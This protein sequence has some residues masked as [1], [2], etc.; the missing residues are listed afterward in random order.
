LVLERPQV[1]S[2]TD[3]RRA[4]DVIE[5]WEEMAVRA[6]KILEDRLILIVAEE[7]AN[8]V[9]RQHLTVGEDRSR[10]A[11]T[12]PTPRQQRRNGFINQAVRRDHEVIQVHGAPPCDSGSAP[13]MGVPGSWFRKPAHH[14]NYLIRAMRR[15]TSGR[16]RGFRQLAVGASISCCSGTPMSCGDVTFSIARNVPRPE[17]NRNA[18]RHWRAR[19]KTCTMIAVCIQGSYWSKFMG[20]DHR[21]IGYWVKRLDRAIEDCFERDLIEFGMGRRHWQ[22]LDALRE[23]VRTEGEVER[24]LAPFWTEHAITWL[25]VLA[26][27]T[28][29]D[30]ITNESGVVELTPAGLAVH[31]QLCRQVAASRQ[32]LSEGISGDDYETATRVLERM[33]S[34]AEPA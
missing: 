16:G 34:N 22:V 15:A 9:H 20:V 31:Q 28:E 21:P 8:D 7:F 33:T 29:R 1:G 19:G 5:G 11:L 10:S 13:L 17:W 26:D 3:E 23:D 18:G 14:V 6:A 12:E 24:M 4:M 32:R 27:L 25:E 2:L 30:L